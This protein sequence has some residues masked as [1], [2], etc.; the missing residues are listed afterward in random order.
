MI[1]PPS[2]TPQAAPGRSLTPKLITIFREGYGAAMLRRD[3]VAGVTVAIV[4][5][6]LSMAI[7][8]ASGAS[9]AA[10]LYS[11]IIGG[12]IVSA[13]GGSRYQIGGPAG[14]FIVLI[15]S[16][17]ERHGFDGLLLTTMMS[18]AILTVLGFL[19]LGGFIRLVPRA[20]LLGFTA[21][22]ALI[23]FASQL[24]DLFGL[25][26]TGRE[27]AALLPKLGLL[28]QAAATLDPTATLMSVAVII[29][30]LGLRRANPAWPG[31]L[32]A[33][34]L[35]AACTSWMSLPVET[36][37][38]RFG[39]IPDGLPWPVL[40]AVD[41]DRLVMLL[42][43]ALAIAFLAGLESLLSAVVADAMS[44]RQHRADAELVAQ[45]LANI[46][47]ALFGGICVTGTIART[48]TNIRAG[49]ASPVSGML[50]SV[51]LLAFML[52][53]AP[54][55]RHI[56]LAALA[57]VLAV[58][59]WNMADRHAVLAMLRH[60]DGHALVLATTFVLTILIDLMVGIGAG[61]ALALAL[62]LWRR[63]N[64]A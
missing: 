53:A 10:G 24:R 19:R 51:L 38:T 35:A 55:A 39:G 6:P 22:I 3:V 8:I 48:A 49:A 57:G 42:P 25:T 50:H 12:F 34:T 40:P 41:T 23:I 59:A 16:I 54:L 58:V 56:P 20:V 2:L 62:H 1:A 9:P 46:G 21:A 29:T 28:W 11:A 7:A 5:L 4:A 32:I 44:G 36:I 17:I 15:G 13:L 43:D 45:G 31:L 18:G 63:R 37:G 47:S 60:G 27:P 14:A 61:C 52:M 30:I 26:V 64:P 33:V